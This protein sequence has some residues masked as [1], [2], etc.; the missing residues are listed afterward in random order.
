[1]QPVLNFNKNFSSWQSDHRAVRSQVNT[2]DNP[3]HPKKSDQSALKCQQAPFGAL[4]HW[5][6]K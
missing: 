6:E 5:M 3:K 2:H 1:M 4:V